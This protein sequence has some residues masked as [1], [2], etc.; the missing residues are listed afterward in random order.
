MRCSFFY[1]H[2]ENFGI[3][4]SENIEVKKHGNLELLE[5]EEDFK[6]RI[7]GKIVKTYFLKGKGNE[8]YLVLFDREENFDVKNFRKKM[9]FKSLKFAENDTLSFCFKVNKNEF[10]ILSALNINEIEDKK[11]TILINENL[12]GSDLYFNFASEFYHLK[13]KFDE[14]LSSWIFGSFV[15]C[16]LLAFYYC[17]FVR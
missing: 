17:V 7:C 15:Q 11:I 10:G 9:N 2:V 8:Y 3:V 14:L 1:L 12:K 16:A 13:L 6:L 5:N 4:K